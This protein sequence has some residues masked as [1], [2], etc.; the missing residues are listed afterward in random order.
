[1]HG[2]PFPRLSDKKLRAEWAH[3]E[4]ALNLLSIPPPS[5]PPRAGGLGVARDQTVGRGLGAG[6]GCCP[7][8]HP[9]QRWGHAL[10]AKV[11]RPSGDPGEGVSA[12]QGPLHPWAPGT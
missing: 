11:R 12:G 8:S 2:A 9:G 3:N 1:M 4:V 5:A 6:W 10:S 7:E